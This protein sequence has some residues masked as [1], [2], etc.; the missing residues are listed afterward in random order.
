MFEDYV[1]GSVVLNL[2]I[3]CTMKRYASSEDAHAKVGLGLGDLN[4]KR[5]YGFAFGSCKK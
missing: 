5:K 4:Y 1:N 2:F 3:G